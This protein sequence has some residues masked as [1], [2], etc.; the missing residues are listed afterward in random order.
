MPKWIEPGVAVQAARPRDRLIG[1]SRH[2]IGGEKY[3]LG[4]SEGLHHQLVGLGG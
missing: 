4:I 3:G 1:V 2:I